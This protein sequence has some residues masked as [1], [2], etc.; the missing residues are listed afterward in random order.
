MTIRA[1]YPGKC[2]KCGGQIQPGEQIN[3]DKATRRTEHA[4]CPKR[5]ETATAQPNA[6]RQ[7]QAGHDTATAAGPGIQERPV[8]TNKKPARC[9]RCGGW[10]M[11]GEGT[12]Y[13]IDPD[14]AYE[15][16]GWVVEHKDP[17]ICKAEQARR[18]ALLAK[19][20]EAY[21]SD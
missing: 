20:A 4:V 17:A 16:S 11:A 18:H 5:A 8:R 3:W 1:R 7:A 15:A 13:Y 14:E 2:A 19:Q 21:T 6:P 9:R 10:V 12:L